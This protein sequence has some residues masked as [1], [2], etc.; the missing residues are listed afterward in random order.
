[1]GFTSDIT[2][3]VDMLNEYERKG[4]EMQR[5]RERRYASYTTPTPPIRRPDY[6]TTVNGREMSRDEYAEHTLAMYDALGEEYPGQRA[7]SMA[8]IYHSPM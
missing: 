5:A 4:V 6:Y 2:A 3:F 1:M 7:E 8:A